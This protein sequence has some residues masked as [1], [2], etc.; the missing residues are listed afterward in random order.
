MRPGGSLHNSRVCQGGESMRR[1]TPTARLVMIMTRAFSALS[2]QGA[3][4]PPR[5]RR[6]VRAPGCSTAISPTSRSHGPGAESGSVAVW[7]K[8][9]CPRTATSS[10]QWLTITSGSNRIGYV[11]RPPLLTE[12]MAGRRV[13]DFHRWPRLQ[14]TE[15]AGGPGGG[16]MPISVDV[17]PILAAPSTWDYHRTRRETT[18]LPV[19]GGQGGR[20]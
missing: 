18:P 16:V 2:G 17:I 3:S 20:R 15:D 8:A 19:D 14:P 1:L 12:V 5:A 11:P 7:V 10:A 9:G 13:V 4:D 6:H